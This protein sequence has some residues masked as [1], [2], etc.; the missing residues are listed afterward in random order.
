MHVDGPRTESQDRHIFT[1]ATRKSIIS[2][3]LDEIQT[4]TLQ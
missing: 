2:E 1:T 4:Q 3:L